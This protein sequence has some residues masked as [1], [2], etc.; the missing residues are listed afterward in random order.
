MSSFERIN[1]SALSELIVHRKTHIISMIFLGIAGLSYINT[2][3]Y[4]GGSPDLYGFSV[5]FFFAALVPLTGLCSSVFRDM[6]NVPVADVQMAMPLSA[7][8]RFLSKLMT[9]C[10]CW[11]FPYIFCHGV[12]NVLSVFMNSFRTVEQYSYDGRRTIIE[13][14]SVPEMFG[15]NMKVFLWG[16]SMALFVVAAVSLCASCVGSRAESSYL[17][18]IMMIVISVLPFETREYIRD[19]FSD[20]YL[21]RNDFSAFNVFGFGAVLFDMDEGISVL[22]VLVNCLISLAMIAA[23]MF[24]YTKR[25]ASTVGYPVVY[26]GF[27]EVL[28]I[29]TLAAVFQLT[30]SDHSWVG[31]FIAFVGSLILRMIVSRKDITIR[32]TAVW[33]GI[34]AFYY[35]LFVLFSYTACITGG[36]GR[37]MIS[38]DTSVLNTEKYEVTVEYYCSRYWR[39]YR[40]YDYRSNS[41]YEDSVD[42]NRIISAENADKAAAVFS[43]YANIQNRMPGFF[44]YSMFRTGEEYKNWYECRISVHGRKT[45]PESGYVSLYSGEIML[46]K[47]SATALFDELKSIR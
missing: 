33:S 8:E 3:M 16:L 31:L 38:P 17:P 41:G 21:N 28:M 10:Y 9:I 23:A 20:V 5:F 35:A 14:A 19:M 34:F 7:S 29:L 27:F 46:D 22:W 18:V 2:G 12:G 4:S 44:T 6:H 40:E 36:F 32:K 42:I 15:A 37:N 1:R 25:D 24:A 39:D 45:G 30:V 13:P 26:R 11:L 47:D 43:K